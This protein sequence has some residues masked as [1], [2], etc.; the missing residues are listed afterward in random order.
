MQLLS[1]LHWKDYELLDCGDLEKLERFG[2]VVL[3][4][5]EPQALWKKQFT[6]QEWHKLA[7]VKFIQKGSHA[8]E[9]KK[10]TNVNDKWKISY[11]YENLAIKFNLSLTSF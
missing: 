6:E 3:R 8:S 1:P 11:N 7:D 4:R 5:P 9:W 10:N 2:D